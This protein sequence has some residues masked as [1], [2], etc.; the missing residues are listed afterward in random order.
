MICY[1]L[2]PASKPFLKKCSN[3]ASV[4][5]SIQRLADEVEAAAQKKIKKEHGANL[6]N[7][8]GGWIPWI[9]NPKCSVN[10][11]YLLETREAGFLKKLL[12]LFI[13]FLFAV[14][15]CKPAKT[16]LQILFWCTYVFTQHWALVLKTRCIK[17]R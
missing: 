17:F 9:R 4:I 15:L 3:P 1:L 12:P 14:E 10:L 16:L 6:G 2:N 8:F 13:P 7:C 5:L 11:K